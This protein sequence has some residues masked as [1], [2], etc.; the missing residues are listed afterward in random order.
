MSH[1]YQ[2]PTKRRSP[3][4]W[5]LGGGAVVLLLCV[6]FLAIGALADNDQTAATGPTGSATTG[7]SQPAAA[8]PKKSTTAGAAKPT[9]KGDD[10]VH[11]GEDVPAGT[12]RGS[13][14]VDGSCYWKK[15]NDAE[16]SDIIDNDIPAGGRP[17]VTLKKG[18]WFTSKRCPDWI[19]Q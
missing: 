1:P 4:P 12:Y 10:L 5:I 19:K 9:I 16:G 15:S 2:P 7:R 3:L 13:E 6:G 14:A 8:A 17:Q 11:V 18:Q